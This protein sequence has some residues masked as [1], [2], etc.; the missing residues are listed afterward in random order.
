MVKTLIAI[1][2]MPSTAPSTLQLPF[3]YPSTTIQLP[4][5]YRAVDSAGNILDFLISAKRD[6]IV[7]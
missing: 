7:L 3:N 1:D 5:N 4:F 6:I 2:S